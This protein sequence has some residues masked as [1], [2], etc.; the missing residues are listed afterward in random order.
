MFYRKDR[1]VEVNISSSYRHFSFRMKSI[2]PEQ[3]FHSGIS[4]INVSPHPR[5]EKKKYI[6]V[7]IFRPGNLSFN[8]VDKLNHRLDFYL[9]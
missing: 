1:T 6:I 4:G 2:Q 7:T 5:L 3:T 8:L 9:A